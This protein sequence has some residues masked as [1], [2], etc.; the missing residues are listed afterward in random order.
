[1]DMHAAFWAN[2][3]LKQDAEQPVIEV[4]M[5]LLELE[6]V[7]SCRFALTGADQGASLA[8]QD[9]QPWRSYSAKPGM[10]LKFNTANNGFRAYL[11]FG[12]QFELQ[13]EFGSIVVC[14][15]SSPNNSLLQGSVVSG[16][17]IDCNEYSQKNMPLEYIPSYSQQLT[18]QLIPG[19]QFEQ[20]GR[21]S[22]DH[23]LKNEYQI[24]NSSN[25]MACQLHGEPI[26][27]LQQSL[28]SEG[29]AFGAVQV[30]QDGQPVILLN[31]R[32]TMGGYP[33][34]GCISRASA[35]ALAQRFHPETVRFELT[36]M[37]AARAEYQEF[38]SFFNID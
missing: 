1:M 25:R 4:A 9:I 3:L 36:N 35:A 16:R 8:G 27:N 18:L 22:I 13:R 20:F 34:L 19:Y 32:Q 26:E 6:F 11:A 33:K 15:S 2:R 28:L 23:L 7:A 14:D 10:R 38:R 12:V 37:E 31:D 30:P 24:Q 17:V 5:G 29:I 21:A